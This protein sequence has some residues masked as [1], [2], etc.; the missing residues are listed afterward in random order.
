MVDLNP[1]IYTIMLNVK[2]QTVYLKGRLSDI[3]KKQ[4]M[5]V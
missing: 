5:A 2:N 1:S 4:D 3:I